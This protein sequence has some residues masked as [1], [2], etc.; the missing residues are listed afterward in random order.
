MLSSGG[1]HSN[2]QQKRDAVIGM[3]KNIARHVPK[4][5]SAVTAKQA[6][7][8]K[9]MKKK[10]K[11]TNTMFNVSLPSGEGE[12]L[13]ERRSFGMDRLFESSESRSSQLDSPTSPPDLDETRS[14][15]DNPA[16]PSDTHLEMQ[17]PQLQEHLHLEDAN[18]D[19]YMS[20]HITVTVFQDGDGSVGDNVSGLNHLSGSREHSSEDLR[21][22]DLQTQWGGSF[23]A[24][25]HSEEFSP[26]N[27]YYKELSCGSD[28]WYSS[29]SAG[30]KG[31]A[32][33]VELNSS[34]FPCH[35]NQQPSWSDSH[36]DIER[37]WENEVVPYLKAARINVTSHSEHIPVYMGSLSST[38][39]GPVHETEQRRAQTYTDFTADHHLTAP[40]FYTA[41]PTAY[42]VSPVQQ[43]L[44]L[45][46]HHDALPCTNPN[47]M[48]PVTDYGGSG[49]TQADAFNSAWAS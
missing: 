32:S 10:R 27:P 1:E 15:T 13:L 9:S 47:F 35:Q 18:T 23:P 43:R 11:K 48:Y 36:P 26:Y 40:Q 4:Q 33:S 24:R 5:S 7:R 3:N 31:Q 44:M 12:L 45:H 19:E 29:A 21:Y 39:R 6:R 16:D 46:A 17:T 38:P 28:L 37:M 34:F 2:L 14:V 8:V 22:G 41:P 42:E 25:P 30:A 20:K 49:W